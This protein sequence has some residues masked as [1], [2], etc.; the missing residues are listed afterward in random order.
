MEFK[1]KKISIAGFGKSGK[2][3]AEILLKNG[4]E[5]FISDSGE[6]SKF[7][8]LIKE[9]DSTKVTYEFGGH[10][11]KIYEGKDLIIISPGVSIYTPAIQEAIK[12]NVSVM[13]EVEI[14]YE[15]AKADIIAITGTNGKSTTVSMIDKM[16]KDHGLKSILAGNIGTPLSYEIYNHKEADY[17]VAEISSF[18]LESISK[19]RPHIGKIQIT[20]Y[21]LLEMKMA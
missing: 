10:T 11:S 2:S 6:E 17:I 8:E 14:A 13:G 4:N 20:I 3:I 21:Y 7:T 15:M 5:I 19:F 12:H 16:L 18:Q 9:L 1:N